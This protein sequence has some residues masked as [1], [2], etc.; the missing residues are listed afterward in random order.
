MQ[1]PLGGR[2]WRFI[3]GFGISL[4]QKPLGGYPLRF[5]ILDFYVKPLGEH[6]LRSVILGSILRKNL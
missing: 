3:Y 1:K 5:I 4:I 6:P 2:P